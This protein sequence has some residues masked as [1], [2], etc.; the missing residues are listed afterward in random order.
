MNE[1]EKILKIT[2][3]VDGIWNL[4]NGEDNSL[5]YEQLY[6]Y[7]H[8][9]MPYGIQK[10]RTGDPDEWISDRLNYIYHR[11]LNDVFSTVQICMC[12]CHKE[13]ADIVHFSPC[14]DF[15]GYKYLDKDNEINRSNLHELIGQYILNHKHKKP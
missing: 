12:L 14:C 13:G 15:T 4:I 10:A 11:I 8:E 3:G 2:N 9:D 7:F 5:I 1:T 6:D